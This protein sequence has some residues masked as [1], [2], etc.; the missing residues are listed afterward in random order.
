LR[1]VLSEPGRGV[2]ETLHTTLGG[3][4]NMRIVKRSSKNPAWADTYEWALV[5]YTAA[6]PVL[7]NIA[8]HLV[9]KREQARFVLWAERHIKG[10]R[11]GEDAYAAIRE[12]MA[13]MKRDPHR[14]SEMAQTR[15]WDAIVGSAENTGT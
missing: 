1:V 14:L 11:A 10:R 4:G 6:C 12:E 15:V 3:S 13:A 5:G 7:R 2:I 9:I 8:N